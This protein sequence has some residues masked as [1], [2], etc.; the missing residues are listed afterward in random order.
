MSTGWRGSRLHYYYDHLS[1]IPS[2]AAARAPQLYERT[3]VLRGFVSPRQRP[4]SPP[5]SLVRIPTTRILCAPRRIVSSH[6]R[7]HYLTATATVMARRPAGSSL[8]VA[9]TYLPRIVFQLDV[10]AHAVPNYR[11]NH[12]GPRSAAHGARLKWQ[13]AIAAAVPSFPQAVLKGPGLRFSSSGR[14]PL[15]GPA[16][17]LISGSLPLEDSSSRQPLGLTA[18]ANIER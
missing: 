1:L 10:L 15:S 14:P 12:A 5:S 8:P 3:T 4:S 13:V 7:T 16:R 18:A 11:A 9:P 17:N 2:D 6:A